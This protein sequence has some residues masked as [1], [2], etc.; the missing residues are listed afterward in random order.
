MNS[1][2]LFGPGLVGGLLRCTVVIRLGAVPRTMARAVPLLSRSVH[3][4]LSLEFYV[5][6]VRKELRNTVVRVYS[7]VRTW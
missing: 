3:D 1:L 2:L 7:L 6:Q 5:W 4:M